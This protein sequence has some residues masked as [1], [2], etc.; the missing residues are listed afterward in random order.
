MASRSSRMLSTPLFDAASISCT[1]TLVPAVISRQA[2]HTLHGVGVGA[3]IAGQ[4]LARMRAA[5]VLPTPRAPVKRN[6]WCRRPCRDGVLQRPRDVLL[7]DDL[8]ERLRAVLAWRGRDS[9]CAVVLA[10]VTRK[11][12]GSGHPRRRLPLL[13]S[14]PGGVRQLHVA[15]SH[16]DGG[17]QL[18]PTVNDKLIWEWRRERDS[19]PRYLSAHTISNRAPSATR[20]SLLIP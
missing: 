11:K 20:A 8:V 14:G 6:A 16:S 4:A 13:P 10:P 5:V 3:L 7:P 15:Q 9:T 19:N 2:S 1:S 17:M 18:Q 12:G